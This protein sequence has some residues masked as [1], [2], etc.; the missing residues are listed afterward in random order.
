MRAAVAAVILTL[1]GSTQARAAPR[2]DECTHQTVTLE[3]ERGLPAGML[4]AISM[5]ESSYGGRPQP[6]A[7]RIGGRSLYPATLSQATRRL[8]A[9]LQDGQ[10]NINAGCMQL[11]LQHH[12]VA[13]DPPERILE[14]A[15]NVRR[16][17]VL[18]VALHR[19][20]HSWT[21]ALAHFQG[22]GVAQQQKYIC[23]VWRYLRVLAP[24]SAAQLDASHC[25]EKRRPNIS[26]L[27]VRQAHELRRK[28]IEKQAKG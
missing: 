24:A 7:L 22:G 8:H 12:G 28:L 17:A 1:I 14:P 2:V 27:V 6:Y 9:A 10:Q 3:H 5:A 26:S 25:Q 18:L 13:F 16:A 11:S 4:L 21:A 23:R 15:G 20:Y 19:D